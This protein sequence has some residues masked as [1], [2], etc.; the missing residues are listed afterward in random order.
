M[1]PVLS[2]PALFLVVAAVALLASCA[3]T[4]EIG[5]AEV[6]PALGD[7][8]T[9]AFA[10]EASGAEPTAPPASRG[11][12]RGDLPAGWTP[13]EAASY[14][15]AVPQDWIAVTNS[16]DIEA[17]LT[18]INGAE[19]RRADVR[20]YEDFLSFG[21]SVVAFGADGDNLN[22]FKQIASVTSLG[23]PD[24]MASQLTS[25][26]RA[27]SDNVEVAAVGRV[28]AGLPGVFTVGSYELDGVT[29][30]M[31]QFATHHGV[32]AYFVTVTLLTG[33]D[34]ALVEQIFESFALG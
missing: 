10:S 6:A 34:H 1:H 26:L 5:L 21:D 29:F 16:R 22:A 15:L 13:V 11:R 18:E 8:E 31:Y 17:S 19:P 3:T 14:R 2:L 32:H 7:V 23:N 25:E 30:D 20:Q 28:F 33:E 4:T 24:A 27:I 12:P 9:L